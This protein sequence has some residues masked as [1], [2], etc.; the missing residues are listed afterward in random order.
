ML[1]VGTCGFAR[2]GEIPFLCKRSHYLLL[3]SG[4]FEYRMPNN[5]PATRKVGKYRMTNVK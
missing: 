2:G 3:F 1:K 4:I 5:E